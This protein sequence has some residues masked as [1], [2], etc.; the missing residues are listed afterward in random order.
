MESEGWERPSTSSNLNINLTY[1]VPSQN[2]ATQRHIQMSLGMIRDGNFTISLPSSF[3]CLYLRRF[4]LNIR[5]RFFTETVVGYWNRLPKGSDHST[6]PAE[7]EEVFEQHSQK[8]GFILRWS[9]MDPGAGL[10][11]PMHSF[12]LRIF[13]DLM[14]SDLPEHNLRPF[15]CVLA[16][17][18]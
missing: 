16:A 13:S 10:N 3:Q 15:P 12:Q 14:I 18:T 11:D 2:H 9:C 4:R 1:Q 8:Y 5:N 7:D 6:E 17:A